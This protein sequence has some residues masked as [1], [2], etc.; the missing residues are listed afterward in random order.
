[1]GEVLFWAIRLVTGE[2]GYTEKVHSAW[3]KVYSRMLRIIV[4]VAI[5]WE[6]ELGSAKAQNDR[7][8]NAS[9]QRIVGMFSETA[10]S[11]APKSNSRLSTIPDDCTDQDDKGKD[12]VA[13]AEPVLKNLAV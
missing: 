7:T 11:N 8:T 3:L 6:L 10:H 2:A 13:Q 1:M 4:P 9:T 12:R 5:S